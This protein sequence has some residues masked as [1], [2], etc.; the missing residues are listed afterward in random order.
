MANIPD[1]VTAFWSVQINPNKI[2][3]V[4]IPANAECS[5]TNA[6]LVLPSDNSIESG[7]VVCY[8]KVNQSEEV[9]LFPFTVGK[10]ESTSTDLAFEENDVLEFRLTGVNASVQVSG[11][12]EGAFHVDTKEIDPK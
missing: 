3:Q 6:A 4:T 9:A 10:F 1:S 8:V 12:L 11:N 7:R 5:L 2:T